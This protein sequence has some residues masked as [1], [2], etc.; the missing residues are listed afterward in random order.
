MLGRIAGRWSSFSEPHTCLRTETPGISA[1]YKAGLE[2]TGLN[3][4]IN[5]AI[6][7]TDEDPAIALEFE[8]RVDALSGLPP[9]GGFVPKKLP[10]D[11]VLAVKGQLAGI[12]GEADLVITESSFARPGMQ[13]TATGTVSSIL[14]SPEARLDLSG[15]VAQISTLPPVGKMDPSKLP[16]DGELWINTTLSN[17]GSTWNL[18]S[19]DAGINTQGL[20]A[21]ASGNIVYQLEGEPVADIKFRLRGEAVSALPNLGFVDRDRFHADGLFAASGQLI[22]SGS[23]W[24]LKDIWVTYHQPGPRWIYHCD[25]K[26]Q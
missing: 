11:G 9:L 23:R 2:Q 18:T 16:L 13:I 4:A 10:I 24:D 17:S 19:L 12:G 7:S 15:K 3:L 6:R 1:E 5:G 26:R 25:R 21:S 14:S 22:G 20:K 8:G